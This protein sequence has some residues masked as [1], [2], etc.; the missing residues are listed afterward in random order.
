M[1]QIRKPVFAGKWYPKNSEN[2][3]IMLDHFFRKVHSEERLK[4]IEPLG[5]IVPHAGY[6][7]SGQVAAYAYSLLHENQFETVILLGSSHRYLENT[8]SVYNGKAYQTP[9]GNVEIDKEIT[10]IILNKHHH[11]GFHDYIHQVEHSLEAQIPFLQYKLKNFQIV[12]ILT[13]TRNSQLLNLLAE[14]LSEII[15]NTPK[16]V[17]LI[18]ST[19]MSHYHSYKTARN[20]DEQTIKL[21]LDENWSEL[22]EAIRTGKSELC[23]YYAM[24]PFLETLKAFQAAQGELLYYANSGDVTNDTNAEQVVG[25]MSMLFAK[26]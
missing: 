26:K 5:L 1:E 4:N 11:F 6:V 10:S 21:L 12:P 9:L 17:L 20:M 18:C 8:I 14:A 23:G 16:K 3:N 24:L 22:A 15:Q 25:Y 2:L 13:S 7:Y 19:D